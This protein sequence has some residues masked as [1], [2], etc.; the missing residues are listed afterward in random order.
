MDAVKEQE[1]WESL[2]ERQK[3][4]EDKIKGKVF[5]IVLIDINNA[6]ERVTGFAR[7]PDLITQLRLIDKSA[8]NDNGFSLE[9]CSTAL[10]SLIITSETDERIYNKQD[11]NYWK[12]ACTTLSQ[13]MTT[14][15]PVLKKK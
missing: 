12:G 14:A 9:A 11:L 10:D 8:G 4:I 5:P 1:F 15:I 6:E 13:F 3:T 7:I 2:E